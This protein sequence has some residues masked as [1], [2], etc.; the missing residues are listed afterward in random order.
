MSE[1]ICDKYNFFKNLASLEKNGAQKRNFAIIFEQNY[2][3]NS[4]SNK[5]ITWSPRQLN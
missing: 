1:K 2:V 4:V 3:K 5:E